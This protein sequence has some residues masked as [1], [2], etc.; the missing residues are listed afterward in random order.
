M[1]GARYATL[2]DVRVGE[3]RIRERAPGRFRSHRDIDIGRVG[4]LERY[5]ADARDDG[6]CQFGALLW[7]V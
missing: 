3:P 6:S 1:T 2:L 5:H 7:C 4:L